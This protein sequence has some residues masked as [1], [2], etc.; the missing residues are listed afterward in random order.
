MEIYTNGVRAQVRA[1]RAPSPALVLM[2][3]PA[4]SQWTSSQEVETL[5]EALARGGLPPDFHRKLRGLAGGD[6][7]DRFIERNCRLFA[8]LL[9]AA[10]AGAFRDGSRVERE[11]L[12]RVLAYVRK[13]E[14]AIPDYRPGGLQDDQQEVRAVTIELGDLL[15]AFKAWRLRH[16]VPVMWSSHGACA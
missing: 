4:L 12:L 2:S 16:Q 15:Q 3:R 9:L 10:E 1:G 13:E 6:L 14:D 11:R 5:R 7:S 8:A